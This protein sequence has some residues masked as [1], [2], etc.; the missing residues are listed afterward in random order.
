ME[1]RHLKKI[2]LCILLWGVALSVLAIPFWSFPIFLGALLGSLI[3]FVNWV[4]F[5][6][7]M[8]RVVAGRNRARWGFLLAVKSTLALAAVAA[9]VMYAPVSVIAFVIGVSSLVLGILTYFV[10]F[11]K[12]NEETVLKEDF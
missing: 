6:Y 2:D 3:A 1:Q 7:L 9:V 4:G 12:S 10:L 5:R 11:A 8:A